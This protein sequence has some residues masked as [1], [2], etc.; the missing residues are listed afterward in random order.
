[1]ATVY[2]SRTQSDAPFTSKQMAIYCW[3]LII[4]GE[5]A[6][7]I[8]FR[9]ANANDINF[10]G[11]IGIGIGMAFGAAVL[12][13]P[14]LIVICYG[15]YKLLIEPFIKEEV[16]SPVSPITPIVNIP[17]PNPTLPSKEV[18]LENKKKEK[19]NEDREVQSAR[20]RIQSI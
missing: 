9:N 7:F 20:S 6:S 2:G 4:L 8:I 16:I 10:F 14:G 13:I 17:Q 18:K 15:F 19:T 1:M 12:G 11:K 3:I 5:I